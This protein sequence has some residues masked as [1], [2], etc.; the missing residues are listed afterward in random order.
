LAPGLDWQ[1]VLLVDRVKDLLGLLF[2]GYLIYVLQINA[3]VKRDFLGPLPLQT[4]GGG[5]TGPTRPESG[6]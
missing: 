5:T 1:R 6:P 2:W 4:S 3:E